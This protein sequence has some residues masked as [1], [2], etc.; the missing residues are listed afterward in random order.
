MKHS[1]DAGRLQPQVPARDDHRLDLERQARIGLD[2]VIFCR[3]K[4]AAQI[5]D[6]AFRLAETTGRGLFTRLAPERLAELPDEIRRALDYD[7]ESRSGI[8][9][10]LEP[11]RSRR[12]ALVSA[13]T[14][15][16]PAVAEAERTLA[17]YGEGARTMQD[18]GVAGL[19]RL[20]ERREEIARHPVVIAA[21]GMDGALPTVL[22][23]LVPSFV[24]ALPTSTGYGAAE[25]GR[26]ALNAALASCAPGLVAVNIDNG[27]GAAS[28]ALRLLRQL[29]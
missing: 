2:E 12:V 29:A 4:T 1:E 16:R 18:I 22:A 5:A 9:G 6:I 8:L 17:Y 11:P 27:F 28:A 23:G 7:P 3:D 24:I 14:S 25:G 15:D 13:G 26:T 19:W 20:L 21:A 10:A